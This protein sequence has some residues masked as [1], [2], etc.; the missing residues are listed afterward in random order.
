M[1]HDKYFVYAILDSSL[2]KTIIESLQSITGTIDKDMFK[3]VFKSENYKNFEQLFV[4][5]G[6]GIY[7]RP[8]EHLFFSKAMCPEHGK[9]FIHSHV[10]PTLMYICSSV[11]YTENAPNFDVFV[12]PIMA[13]KNIEQVL[14][15]ETALIYTLNENILNYK[16]SVKDNENERHFLAHFLIECTFRFLKDAVEEI[17]YDFRSIPEFPI[18]KMTP[19]GYYEGE[20]DSNKLTYQGSCFYQYDS[21]K[22]TLENGKTIDIKPL[23]AF[24]PF[25]EHGFDYNL[26]TYEEQDA[27][28]DKIENFVVKF[29]YCLLPI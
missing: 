24:L 25:G 1:F 13:V 11:H 4:Y 9:V 10:S 7:T 27:I 5:I 19:L 26:P 17:K 14:K 18:H 8:H 3:A 22:Y 16:P 20:I 23:F 2:V 15:L 29:K 12:F 6:S 28:L 21:L